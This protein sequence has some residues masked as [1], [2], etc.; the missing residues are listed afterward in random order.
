MSD[1]RSVSH[2]AEGVEDVARRVEDVLD[3]LAFVPMLVGVV[4]A[5]RHVRRREARVVAGYLPHA[6]GDAP[7]LCQLASPGSRR[8]LRALAHKRA[9]AAGRHAAA[10]FEHT[11]T[12]LAF[13]QR[14]LESGWSRA[15]QRHEA[16]L[17][18]LR[19]SL[20]IRLARLR[21]L[22]VVS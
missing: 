20:E 6:M 19:R 2:R 9:G 8:R 5:V 3:V 14:R 4:L 22:H 1:A 12:E 10:T 18:E 16:R 7:L 13:L 21:A 15:D 11:A 17:A